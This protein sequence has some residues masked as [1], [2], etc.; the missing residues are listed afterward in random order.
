MAMLEKPFTAEDAES[1]EE[2]GILAEPKK[3]I[4]GKQEALV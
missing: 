2:L 4:S 3:A 1:A